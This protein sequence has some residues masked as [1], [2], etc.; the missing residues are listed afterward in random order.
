MFVRARV[1]TGLL[2]KADRLFTGTDDGRVIELVQNSR[3]ANS[4]N[5]WITQAPLQEGQEKSKIIFQDDGEG[6]KNF[7][8]LLDLGGLHWGDE[9]VEAEDPGGIGL[10][11]LAPG[12]V[13]I[14]SH[15]HRM[16]IEGEGWW[17]APV[18]VTETD[19]APRVGTKL[20]FEDE[21]WAGPTGI[22][23]RRFNNE[24]LQHGK[25]SGVKIYYNNSPFTM[26]SFLIPSPR[27]EKF[28]PT[29]YPELGVHIQVI[30][31]RC[32]RKGQ[33][34]DRYVYRDYSIDTSMNF[35]GHVLKIPE[36][37]WSFRDSEDGYYQGY[38]YAIRVDMTGEPTPIRLMLPA[39][40]QF[41]ENDAL[42]D[43]QKAIKT[44]VYR[45]FQR[46]GSHRIPY[47]SWLE[48]KTLGIELPEADQVYSL[49]VHHHDCSRGEASAERLSYEIPSLDK[50]IRCTAKTRLKLFIDGK[51][52][53]NMNCEDK[54][55]PHT[56]IYNTLLC[57]KFPVVCIS[58][59]YRGYS[60]FDLPGYV[61]SVRIDL[62]GN[63]NS[64]RVGSDSMILSVYE[65][66]KVTLSWSHKGVRKRK[67][68]DFDSCWDSD[69]DSTSFGVSKDALL[70]RRGHDHLWY[71]SGG[72]NDNS[73]DSYSKQND[74]F[75]EE[76]QQLRDR[77][78]SPHETLR[79]NCV[80]KVEEVC[81]RRSYQSVTVETG[82]NVHIVYSDGHELFM[83]PQ[84]TVEKNG[85]GECSS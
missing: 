61:T 78:V 11:S 63:L 4:R 19:Q 5:I 75:D 15:G 45:Y 9:I 39:R 1:S 18:E 14:L 72:Y 73:D 37:H 32:T 20:I 41:V 47:K 59:D 74:D 49:G 22:G 33:D 53:Y 46:L 77:F 52:L 23:T 30:P 62:N 34:Q 55:F 29:H 8:E 79:R 26:E 56:Q 21:G 27:C 2:R 40:T 16:V 71:L 17:G 28:L 82:G 67:T 7:S 70:H 60:W 48:A 65:E 13:E 68:T 69:D 10:F 42:K 54:E 12:R 64:M 51:E 3:R 58:E 44:E 84:G 38:G 80:E 36:S 6:I 50:A 76:V 35:Y 24:L 25:F 83:T 43:L 66:I 85:G 31:V 57:E 81:G